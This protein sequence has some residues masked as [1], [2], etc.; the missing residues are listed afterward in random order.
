MMKVTFL[1]IWL[2]ILAF[3]AHGQMKVHDAKYEQL[4][5]FQPPSILLRSSVIVKPLQKSLV[6]SEV[7]HAEV[8]LS[9]QPFFCRIEDEIARSAKVNVKFRLG[10]VQYVDVLEG[11]GYFEA[12]GYS[13]ATNFY[14]SRKQ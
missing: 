3:S 2:S 7:N 10:S 4:L 11:K 12:V 9:K 6:L 13:R 14:M 1:T 5:M 8:G